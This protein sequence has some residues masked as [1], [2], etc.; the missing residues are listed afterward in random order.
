MAQR[1]TNTTGKHAKG[2]PSGSAPPQDK[3][4]VKE[5]KELDLEREEELRDEY[6][7]EEGNPDPDK[8]RVKNPNRNTDKVK[9]DQPSYGNES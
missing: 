9:I 7:D 5:A 3:A 8:V 1:D 4:S 2:K 6:T